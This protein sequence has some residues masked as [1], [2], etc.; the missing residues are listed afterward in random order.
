MGRNAP[1]ALAS[2]L[3]DDALN[4]RTP[5]IYDQTDKNTRVVNQQETIAACEANRKVKDRFSEWIWQNEDRAQRLARLYNDRFN[6]I[7]LRTY[8]GSHLTFPG[9]NRS[10]PPAATISIKHQKRRGLAG[11]PDAQYLLAAYCVGAGKNGASWLSMLRQE[12]KPPVCLATKPMIV[13]PNHLVEQWGAAFL[14][15]YPHA[16]LFVAG[17]EVFAAFGNRQKLRRG[18]RDR[19]LRRGNRNPTVCFKSYL[20]PIRPSASSASRSEQLEGGDLWR[21]GCAGRQ[22]SYRQ[23]TGKGKETPHD[24]LKDRADREHKDETPLFPSK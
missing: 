13:V 18:S 8:D 16:Q 17:K 7:R 24:E 12:M 23:G 10:L 19:Y 4:G 6:N 22:P 9:L 2:D 5:T 21:K 20:C 11:A 14:A 1:R 3:I 15:L